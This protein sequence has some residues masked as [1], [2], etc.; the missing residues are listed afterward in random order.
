MEVTKLK[1]TFSD[2]NEFVIVH[3]DN[4]IDIHV[5]TQHRHDAP[6][7]PIQKAT[8]RQT[9]KYMNSEDSVCGV[10]FEPA[11]TDGLCEANIA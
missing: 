7:T 10:T 4:N 1:V 5:T 8:I 3:S 9:F 11:L 2:S 6:L